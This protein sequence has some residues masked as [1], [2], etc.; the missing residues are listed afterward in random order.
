[1]CIIII[2]TAL[3]AHYS[4]R[5]CLSILVICRR[6]AADCRTAVFDSDFARPPSLYGTGRD[7]P[8]RAV[9]SRSAR[10]IVI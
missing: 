7:E 6:T 4:S 5:R 8:S 2:I 9:C 10:P 3:H 1:M